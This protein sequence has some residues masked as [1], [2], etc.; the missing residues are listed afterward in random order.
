MH[1]RSK[2]DN[3]G[4]SVNSI[5]MNVIMQTIVLL[6]LLDN[7][8]NASWV[9]LI[10][11]GMGIAV[12]AWKITKSVNIRLVKVD[13]AIPHRIKFE[14]KHKLNETEQATKDYDADATK[15][16]AYASAP[17]LVLYSIYSLIY[18]EHKGWW[19]FVVTTLVSFVYFWGF[20]TMV[21]SLWINYKLKSVAHMST[22]ALGYK[23]LNT[24]VCH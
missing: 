23:F 19:S 15:Y 20:L 1:F 10:G 7:Q 12:E 8:E 6:Y 17:L 3:T 21:P 22:R 2:K 24:I 14:D 13:T 4:V 18:E 9:I 5:L 16:L 11:Q